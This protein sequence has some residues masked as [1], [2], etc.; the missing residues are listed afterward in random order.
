MSTLSDT[1]IFTPLVI[2]L[3]EMQDWALQ[4]FPHHIHSF[5]FFSLSCFPSFQYSFSCFNHTSLNSEVLCIWCQ[6]MCTGLWLCISLACRY[7]CLVLCW[8]R[9]PESSSPT[10]LGSFLDHTC[11]VRL[12]KYLEGE[13]KVATLRAIVKATLDKEVRNWIWQPV[14]DQAFR[15]TRCSRRSRRQF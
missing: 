11:L 6:M 4:A 7:C 2:V 9:T 1:D 3:E 15:S 10:E 12:Q 14:F 5:L 13:M 8:D